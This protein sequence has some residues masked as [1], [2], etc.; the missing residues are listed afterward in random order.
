MRLLLLFST[1]VAAI[2]AAKCT[3]KVLILMSS[4]GYVPLRN[5]TRRWNETVG[6]YLDELAIPLAEMRQRGLTVRVANPRGN[7]PPMDPRSADAKYFNGSASALA[8][9]LRLVDSAFLGLNNTMPVSDLAASDLATFDAVFIPGGH[10]PMVDLFDNAD[11]GRVLRFFHGKRKLT[12]AICHGPV[13]LG[14]AAIGQDAWPYAGYKFL[15]FSNAMDE[16]LQRMWG[17]LLPFMPETFLTKLGGVD[18]DGRV[19]PY[20]PNAL[21]DRELV[22]GQNPMS[23]EVFKTLFMSQYEK[24]C[25]GEDWL[26]DE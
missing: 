22:F 1:F 9:A 14:A 13:A 3:G 18:E 23:A 12:G 21:C 8:A 19:A 7:R 15:V 16:K 26:C 17:G 2:A 10:P 24:M 5:G 20:A 6:Y 11:V 4:V 25:A